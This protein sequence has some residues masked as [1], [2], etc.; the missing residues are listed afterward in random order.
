[1]G[2][3]PGNT[4]IGGLALLEEPIS[5]DEMKRLVRA[6]LLRFPR[7]RQRPRRPL[8]WPAWPLWEEDP[9]F[10]LERHI[11]ALALPD[12]DGDEALRLAFQELMSEPLPED[13]PLWSLHLLGD[14]ESGRALVLRFEHALADG[15]AMMAV[16][17]ALTDAAPDAVWWEPAPEPLQSP[18]LAATLG[19]YALATQTPA[20]ARRGLGWVRHPLY[21]A[22]WSARAAR[23][24][25]KLLFAPP[26]PQT[27]LRGRFDGANRVAWS[28]PVPL[29]DVKAVGK[30][31]GA[32]VNDIMLSAMS[33]GFRRYL[34]ARGADPAGLAL[35]SVTPVDM[36]GQGDA[37][38]L[39][40][41]F[42]LVFL[43]LPVGVEDPVERLQTL[44]EAMTAIKR[45]PEAWVS[46]GILQGLGLVPGRLERAGVRFF[47]A[48]GTAT[49]TNVRGP[50]QPR[51]LAG[52]R[53][54]RALFAV[55]HPGDLA[56]GMSIFSYAGEI[57]VTLNTAAAVIPHPEDIIAGFH[58][59]FRALQR[60]VGADA[61][62]VRPAE[63]PWQCAEPDLPS[64]PQETSIA[65]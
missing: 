36:R 24:L 45:T 51:Y 47:G 55:P 31:L 52:R 54:R 37:S 25:G 35:R 19:A 6:R 2:F 10:A 28:D 48:K 58:A 29:A 26:D 30:A 22:G 20:L 7:F 50:A 11:H 13:R 40:N 4:M 18:L 44:H 60:A 34:L 57:S 14:G 32:T 49:M 5:L 43:T 42:G 16:I 21:A 56:I 27:I 53:I 39:G 9:A 46:L 64:S 63:V 61:E 8:P 33:G 65:A 15:R 62:P 59:D 23:A 17:A 38:G 12:G 1:M 41:W 3:M